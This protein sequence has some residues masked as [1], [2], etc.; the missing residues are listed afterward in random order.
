[1]VAKYNF[2]CLPK[3]G[4]G[5]IK[6]NQGSTLIPHVRIHRYRHLVLQ[7]NSNCLLI[8]VP[9]LPEQKRKNRSNTSRKPTSVASNLRPEENIK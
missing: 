3:L 9:H 7:Q 4:G 8:R 2:T 6:H 5:Y 1:M